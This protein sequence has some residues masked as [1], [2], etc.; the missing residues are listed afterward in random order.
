MTNVNVAELKRMTFRQQ[1]KFLF[2]TFQ[3]WGH[4]RNIVNGATA[5]SQFVKLMSEFG[6]LGSH[7]AD[8]SV[9]S[10]D[11]LG[12][13]DYVALLSSI[14]DDIGDNVVV[15]AIIAAQMGVDIESAFD[16]VESSPA[17]EIGN[18]LAC[19][20][21]ISKAY[22]NMADAILKKNTENF[23]VALGDSLWL[24]REM[25]NEM[26]LNFVD[27]CESAWE[28]IKDRKGVMYNGTFVKSTDE[29]YA[30]IVAELGWE[31]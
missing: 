23:T 7:L 10:F 13:A 24:L 28:D 16:E 14:K 17:P 22:G 1:S 31:S 21:L 19:H 25:A 3:A 26:S 29:N 2:D 12:D 30:R 6:E 18:A 4:A 8:N 15:L 5:I 20:A 27:C 9:E 11:G